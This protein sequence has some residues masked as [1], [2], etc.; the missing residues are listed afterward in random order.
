MLNRSLVP[1]GAVIVALV[2]CCSPLFAGTPQTPQPAMGEPLLSLSPLELQRFL[3]GQNDYNRTITEEEGLGP[4]FNKESCGNCHANPLGGTGSQLVTR[5]GRFEKK[6]FDELAWLGGPLLQSQTIED[7]CEEVVPA[8]A[9]HTTFRVT[10]GALGYGL[11]EAI[12]DA[13]LEAIANN[14]PAPGISGRAHM[15]ESFEDPGVP[16]VGRFGWKAQIATILTFSADASAME[17]GLT[18]RF[19][20]WEQEANGPGG[21]KAVIPCDTIADPEDGPDGNGLDF[22]DRVTDFQRFLAAPPQ[23]PQTGMWG[24]QVFMNVGCGHCH[25]PSFMTSTDMSIEEAIRGKTIRPYSDFLLHDMGANAD[26]FPQGDAFDRE[27][28]TPPLWGLRVRDP[29]WHDGRF[30]GDTFQNRVTQAILAHGGFGSEGMNSVSEFNS[31]SPSDRTALFN[32]LDSLGRREF[33]A[34]GDGFVLISDFD[35]FRACFDAGGAVTPDDPC[36]F[37]DINQDGIVD[38]ADFASFVLAWDGPFEDCNSNGILDIADIIA[39]TSADANLDNIPDECQLANCPADFDDSQSVDF[40]DLLT[41][42]AAWGP[43]P[44]CPEDLD[45][46]NSVDFADAL[47]LFTAWGAC[48]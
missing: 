3:D 10:N 36:A 2:G 7:G 28:R 1:G 27:M 24:E 18:N 35:S 25:T 38:E 26:F 43:C 17:V 5:F 44:G 6:F 15:V 14:P 42:L 20:L 32:F 29:L 30:G 16:R 19:M 33:D 34:D 22:I 13:D 39:G 11:I 46:T 47:I 4:I 40:L 48:P 31:L 23:T 9:N 41:L 37:H 45:G 12:P 21:P 8:L